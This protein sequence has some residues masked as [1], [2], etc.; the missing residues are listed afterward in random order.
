[1]T[2]HGRGD[3]GAGIIST[4][5]GLTS[6]LIL[7]LFAVQV[8]T[9]LYATSVVTSATY[10]AARRAA[11]HG[12]PPSAAEL[13][14]AEDHARHLLGRMG[15]RASFDW[16]GTDADAVRLRV[17]V[18]NPRLVP[19]VPVVGLD[20]VDRTVTVRVEALR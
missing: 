6:F 8:L 2:R 12:H 16:T 1:M 19:L 5:A 20:S 13:A 14:D 17:Q 4:L 11:T 18:A 7:Q 3:S 9:N 15:A 10:D